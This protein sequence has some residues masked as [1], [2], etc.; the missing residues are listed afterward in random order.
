MASHVQLEMSQG[1]TPYWFNSTAHTQKLHPLLPQLADCHPSAVQSQLHPLLAS[2]CPGKKRAW[3]TSRY[4]V[5]SRTCGMSWQAVNDKGR[6]RS[7][8]VLLCAAVLSGDLQDCFSVW[9]ATAALQTR[10]AQIADLRR[11]LEMQRE[12]QR[13]LA[14]TA[15]SSDVII[16]SLRNKISNAE[17]THAR[18][19]SM[20]AEALDSARRER[21]A[22]AL[23]L[24]AISFQA[25][26]GLCGQGALDDKGNLAAHSRNP[27]SYLR[28]F[29]RDGARAVAALAAQ[30]ARLHR[31][32]ALYRQRAYESVE[33][34]KR[35]QGLLDS[36]D[37]DFTVV[38]MLVDVVANE[39]EQ[40][41][42]ACGLPPLLSK[43]STEMPAGKISERLGVMY[44]LLTALAAEVL[45]ADRERHSQRAYLA[46]MC[47]GRVN[48]PC[49]RPGP[50][51]AAA[52]GSAGLPAAGVLPGCAAGG[53]NIQPH[54]H[55]VPL[56]RPRNKLQAVI[57][58]NV[59]SMPR[60]VIHH[61]SDLGGSIYTQRCMIYSLNDICEAHILRLIVQPQWDTW[62]RSKAI[63]KHVGH[64]VQE[65]AILA[66]AMDTFIGTPLCTSLLIHAA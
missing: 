1:Q 6:L 50:A 43:D 26:S 58:S 47:P 16:R 14:K 24:A 21:M 32:R 17:V 34:L 41:A 29:D 60:Q 56:Y 40:V 13:A 66:R 5:F 3:S 64:T 55:H 8:Y 22:C 20:A 61:A 44:Q 59:M 46:A 7:G 57:C 18:A 36:I 54:M 38:N 37:M 53:A 45:L 23:G 25:V 51:Q 65:H 48:Q 2:L 42:A 63:F 27:G 28:P 49:K 30:V 15:N 52:G 19:M 10:D 4:R 39:A 62:L 33:Q 9:C 11:L 12:E 31:Q 35:L